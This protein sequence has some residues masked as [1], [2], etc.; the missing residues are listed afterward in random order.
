[1]VDDV[2]LPEVVTL[3]GVRVSTHEP[4]GSELSTTLPVTTTQVGCV[5]SPITGAEGV[6]GCAFI[7]AFPEGGDVHPFDPVTVKV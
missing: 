6:A 4:A 2:P 3:P 5:I 1:M 7:T